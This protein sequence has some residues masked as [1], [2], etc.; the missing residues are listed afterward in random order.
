MPDSVDTA[1]R[2]LAAARLLQGL[3]EGARAASSCTLL[4]SRSAFLQP[5]AAELQWPVEVRLERMHSTHDLWWRPRGRQG[6]ARF[7]GTC[8]Q[9]S[10]A[11]HSSCAHSVYSSAAASPMP[12]LRSIFSVSRASSALLALGPHQTPF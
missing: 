8:Q 3:P 11:A 7:S 10:P 1:C 12:W 6:T 5:G 2:V 4:K 9:A